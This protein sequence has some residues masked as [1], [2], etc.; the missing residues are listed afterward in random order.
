MWGTCVKCNPKDLNESSSLAQVDSIKAVK[1]RALVFKRRFQRF[2]GSYSL[3][4]THVM[5]VVGRRNMCGVPVESAIQN[6]SMIE[7]VWHK[8]TA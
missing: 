3:T 6:T 4:K 8:L 1:C 5:T 7:A 2:F